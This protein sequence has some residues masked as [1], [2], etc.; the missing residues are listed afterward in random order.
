MPRLRFAL[1]QNFPPLLPGVETL[2]PEVEIAHVQK[3]DPRMPRLEDRELVI[4]L[5]QLGWHGLITN[6]YKMLW[7]PVEIAAIVKTKLTVF[8][9]R[10]VG[11]DPVR[12]TGAVLLDFPGA[13]KRIIAGKSHVFLVSPRNPLPREG[14]EYFKEAAERRRVTPSELYAEVKVTDAELR[15][16]ILS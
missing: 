11:D 5:H 3:I 8:A 7:Q 10:G 4:S 6:N 1:D 15:A 16:P 13:L 14:W 12:A 2:L 9:V